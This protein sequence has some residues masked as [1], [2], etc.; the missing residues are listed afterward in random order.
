MLNNATRIC[1]AKFG[2][3][4]LHED[5]KFRPAAV[6]SPAPEFEAFV[7]ERGAFTPTPDQPLNQLLTT[8]AVVGETSEGV[9]DGPEHSFIQIWRCQNPHRCAD[10]E[11]A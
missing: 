6:A 9:T 11:G 4:Y 7:T 2:V 1:G 5:G 3:L 10:A 8:K